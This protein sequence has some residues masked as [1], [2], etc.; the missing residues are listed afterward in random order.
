MPDDDNP[1]AGA[2]ERA[3]SMY[4]IIGLVADV[5][6]QMKELEELERAPERARFLS[7]LKA[8]VEKP[9]KSAWARLRGNPY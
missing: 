4:S 9:P 5:S 3:Q 1:W 8:Y 7:V 6:R 2:A